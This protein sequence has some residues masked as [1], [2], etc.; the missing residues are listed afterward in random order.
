VKGADTF[1]VQT[2]IL[3]ETLADQQRDAATC[4]LPD[5]PC[6]LVQVTAGE[7]LVGG[8]EEGI[9]T[10]LQHH[11]CD[12][13]PLLPSGIYTGRVVSAGVEK[14]DRTV[15]SGGESAEEFVA[16]EANSLGVVVLVGGRVDSDVPENSKV[17]Y[18]ENTLGTS[19]D[20]S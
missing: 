6:V 7:T 13:T 1:T 11:I 16:G 12:L 2:G 5:G 8:V 3:G 19:F 18:C 15:R 10:F 4:E 9:V 20:V 17:V 14:K